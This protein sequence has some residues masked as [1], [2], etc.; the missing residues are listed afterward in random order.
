P[1]DEILTTSLSWVATATAIAKT[2]ATPVFVDICDDLNI[3][4]DALERAVTPRTRGIVPVHYCGRVCDMPRILAFGRE[5]N[6]AVVEDAAQAFGASLNGVNAGAF[7]DLGAFSINPMKVLRSMGEAGAITF[8]DVRLAPRL[9]SLRYLGTIDRE[10]C[11][12]AELNHK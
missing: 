5:R 2:G 10:Q 3:D 9:A 1:G 4:P 7:G 8:K 6:L 12:E 11:V